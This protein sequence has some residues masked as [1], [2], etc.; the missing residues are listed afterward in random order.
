MNKKL[1]NVFVNKIEKQLNNNERLYYSSQTQPNEEIIGNNTTNKKNSEELIKPPKQK[2]I[3]QK[4]NDI[5]NSS[6]Y[7]YKA[8]VEITLKSGT[9]TKKIIGKNSQNLIT[10][11]NELIPISDILD[12][13]F[14]N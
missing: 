8:D 4:I 11:E 13:K 1:P 14:K 12:I 5:F 9:V 3:N 10:Y 6:R 7:V 2:N